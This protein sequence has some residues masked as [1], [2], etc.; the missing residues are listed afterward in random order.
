MTSILSLSGASAFA[1]SEAKGKAQDSPGA[2]AGNTAQAPM[3]VPVNVCGNTTNVA[4]ALNPAFGNKCINGSDHRESHPH[5]EQPP[6]HG[7]HHQTKPESEPEHESEPHARPPQDRHED[8]R[9]HE[10]PRGHDEPRGHEEGASNT[11]EA[12]VVGH[13]SDSP[14]AGSGNTAQTPVDAPVQAC[15]NHL[16]LGSLLSSIFGNG[17]D[18]PASEPGEKHEEKAPHDPAPHGPGDGH[19]VEPAPVPLVVPPSSTPAHKSPAPKHEPQ[20]TRADDSVDTRA[21]LAETGADEALYGASA[22]SAALLLSGV[23][24]YRRRTASSRG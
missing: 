24:L 13:A 6:H 12:V 22:A 18:A 20:T 16:G 21:K 8:P 17:C 11:S 10:E 5:H 14:G 19:R 3:D 1:D 2:L 23:I 15:G 7:G 4:A 9:G